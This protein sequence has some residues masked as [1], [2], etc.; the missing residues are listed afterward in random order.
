MAEV[1][2]TDNGI[3]FESRHAGRIF[4]VFER[5]HGQGVYAGTGIGLALC[6]RIAERHGGSISA[7]GAPGE[8]ATFTVTLPREPDAESS[9]L[10]DPAPRK[11]EEERPL[12]H[13]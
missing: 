13:A 8:G 1:T 12:V 9:T 5:L 6:R 10:G 2:V 3:G 7:E 11:A 4:R